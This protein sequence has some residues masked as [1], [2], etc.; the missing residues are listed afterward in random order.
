M[1]SIIIAIVA[2]LGAVASSAIV[3][4]GSLISA[5]RVQRLNADKALRKYREPLIVAAYDLQSRIFNILRQDFLAY[6]RN[7]VWGRRE[8][9]LG[10]TSFVFAQWF[11]WREILRREVELLEFETEETGHLLSR[12]TATF[13]SDDHGPTFLL[14]KPEQRAIGEGMIGMW[15]GEASCV[16]YGEFLVRRDSSLQPLL[17]PLERDV[18]ALADSHPGGVDQRLLEVQHLLVELIDMLDVGHRRY[19]RECLRRA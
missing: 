17:S 5:R 8:T 1:T 6:V 18:I 19:Q 2:L 13:A 16:G 10:S 3:V 15:R 4:W 14:W 11:G 12:I 7:D 9:A